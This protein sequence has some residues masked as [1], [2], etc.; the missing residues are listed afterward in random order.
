MGS[1][2]FCLGIHPILEDAHARWPVLLFRV[3]CDDVHMAGPDAT[4]AEEFVSIRARM[5]A[6]GLTM[7][8]GPKKTCCW[9]PR[10][11]TGDNE[12]E[13]A[14]RAA[15]AMFRSALPAE[16]VR[17]GGGMRVLGAYSDDF[18]SA[19]ALA[20]V[21]AAGLRSFA[22]ACAEIEALARSEARN[23]RDITG[24]VLRRYNIRTFQR[25]RRVQPD[26][27]SVARVT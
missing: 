22:T 27:R 11:P 23:A 17:L 14:D 19:T 4:V 24:Q 7:E 12:D 20:D 18:V 16:V 2:L 13:V 15:R 3:I 5:A 25:L 1:L 6:I 8:N 10:F 26:F 9:A 21:E